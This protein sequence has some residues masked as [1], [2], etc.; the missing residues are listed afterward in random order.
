ML[1]TNSTIICVR[2]GTRVQTFA[3]R[4]VRVDTGNLKQSIE[5]RVTPP[6]A[7]VGSDED[8]AAWVHEGTGV[9]G[10]HKQRIYPKRGSYLVFTAKDGTVVFARSVRGMRPNR[11]LTRALRDSFKK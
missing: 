3:R 1:F 4:Y 2:A 6:G 7:Q 8:Y 10:P 5:V 11:Y 9:F